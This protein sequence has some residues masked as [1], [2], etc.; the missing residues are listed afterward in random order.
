M[1]DGVALQKL[2]SLRAVNGTIE[3]DEGC[4]ESLHKVVWEDRKEPKEKQVIE[5]LIARK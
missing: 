3:E 5:I 4:I 1:A 2:R